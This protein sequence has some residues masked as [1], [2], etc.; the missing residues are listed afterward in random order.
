MIVRWEL[1][2]VTREETS[3][4]PQ[5]RLVLRSSQDYTGDFAA[6]ALSSNRRPAIEFGNGTLFASADTVGQNETQFWVGKIVTRADG[7]DELFFR[8]FGEREPFDLMEPA[9][10]NVS[11]RNVRSNANLDILVLSMPGEGSRWIRDVRIGNSWRAVVPP[12]AFPKA[13]Q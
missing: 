13:D 3:W 11:T 6:F 4:P 7:D 5:V 9:H 1:A 10:W 8:I 12:K 2:P